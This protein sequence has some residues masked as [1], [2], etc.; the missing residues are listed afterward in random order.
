MLALG[1]LGVAGTVVG[2]TGLLWGW[3]SGTSP[4]AG[5][6]FMEPQLLRSANGRLQVKLEAAE[7]QVRIAGRQARALSYNGGLPGPT[8]FVRP[9]DRMNVTLQNGLSAATNLHVHG[10]HVSPEGNSDNVLVAVEP[11]TSFEYEYLL[12]EN[13]PPGVYWYHPHHHGMAADQVFGGLYGAIVVE[14][15]NSM[16]VGRE[17]IL[18]IS[19]ISVDGSGRVQ[20]ASAMDRMAGREGKL[21]LVNGQLTPRLNARPVERERWRIIN[22]CVSRYL[23]LRLDGQH[24]QLLGMDSGRF[25]SPKDIEEVILAPGNRAD[26]LVTT[27][28]GHRFCVRCP[29]TGAPLRA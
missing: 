24:L 14:D 12:P 27:T 3:N 28:A 1:G 21:V 15:P 16:P 26:L 13:H 17:R 4:V 19:D 23:R 8:L 9:G 25:A 5:P 10:L 22:A 29:W 11:G 18:V 6:K 7:G 2:G 20:T